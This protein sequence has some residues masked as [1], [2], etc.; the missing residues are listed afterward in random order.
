MTHYSEEELKKLL[1]DNPDLTVVALTRS[2]AEAAR[3]AHNLGGR[4]FESPLRYQSGSLARSTR[5][6]GQSVSFAKRASARV[7]RMFTGLRL[8]RGVSP[9]KVLYFP[10][11]RREVQRNE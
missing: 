6:A 5:P 2:G 11:K 4:E 3:Q 8:Q 1:Q 9:Q 10:L 7:V